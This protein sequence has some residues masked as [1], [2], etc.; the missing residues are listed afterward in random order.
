MK[1]GLVA[2]LKSSIRFYQ[3]IISP[4]IHTL[5]GAG[6]GC[7]FEESCSHY[8]FRMIEE[9]GPIAGTWLAIKRVSSCHPYTSKKLRSYQHG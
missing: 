1:H 9:K 8:S 5:L 6:N 7:R 2:I 4:A 3:W